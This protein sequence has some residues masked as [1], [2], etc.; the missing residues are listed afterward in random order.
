[1]TI[2]AEWEH[3]H[4]LIVVDVQ[5][6]F[7]DPGWGRRGNPA[8]EDN[9]AALIAAWR[10]R[11]WTVVFVRHD[12]VVPG[13]PLAPGS[14]GNS[15][16]EQ[17][18]GEPDVL[19]VKHTNSAFYGAPDLDRVLRGRRIGAVAI[20]GVTTNHCCETTARMAGNLGYETKFVLDATYTFDRRA[21]DG[22]L[23]S[24][25]E[26]MRVTA[27]NLSEEFATV[28]STREV[29]SAVAANAGSALAA[30]GARESAPE[31]T[32]GA[33]L[34][35]TRARR[36]SRVVHR[37]RLV[38]LEPL[39]AAHA[40][41]LF[42]ATHAPVATD[43]LWDFLPY[44]PFSSSP[45]LAAWISETAGDDPRFFALCCPVSGR[46]RGVA[47]LM[48]IDPVHGVIEIGHIWL[49]PL[50]QRSAAATEAIFLLMQ[51]AFD[52]LGY[53]R[54][55]WKCDALNTRS[56]RA[57][58]RLGFRYEGTFRQAAVV[59]GRNRDTAWFSVL[60]TEWPRV[61]GGL[62]AWLREDNFDRD[63]RQRHSLREV[64]QRLGAF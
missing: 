24:A 39:A 33:A 52:D 21:L 43:E 6:G 47:S 23:I 31:R 13:S 2:T 15:F 9:V 20:C 57:A 17:I 29:V 63:G 7:D 35:W 40:P 10:E 28:L 32:P 54:L 58:Q 12:S 46:A 37:G 60:D 44:G 25:G 16:K 45:E 4:A 36:P 59:K 30:T 56:R 34:A 18:T 61:G 3:E 27:A 38:A 11:G 50:I 49:S 55:E 22:E 26:L 5:R 41:A 62:R 1:M 14:P 19:I 48:R 53:R 42:A 8:C 51:H 64:R